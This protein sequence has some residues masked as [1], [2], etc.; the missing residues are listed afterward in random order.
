MR[1]HAR[2]QPRRLSIA[3]CVA[4]AAKCSA[5]NPQG[6]D[7]FGGSRLQHV[8]ELHHNTNWQNYSGETT[9]TH[10]TQMLGLTVHNFVSAATGLPCLRPRAWLCSRGIS[11]R[12]QL[13]GRSHARDAL[14]I[15]AA[16]DHRR[17]CAR[18]V[19]TRRRSLALSKR[20]R[21]RSQADHIHWPSGEQEAIKE[22]G[23]NGGGFFNANSAILMKTPTLSP[24]CSRYGP[25]SLS[26]RVRVRI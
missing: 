1:R 21:S 26:L 2:F 3:L 4:T 6:F 16:G 5:L 12:R 25:S 24:T 13:L 9:M 8:D 17:S 22:L 18:R 14:C 10:L 7:P 23:T 11:D 20:P 15:A 19:R